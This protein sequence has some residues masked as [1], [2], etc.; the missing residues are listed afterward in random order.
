MAVEALCRIT[1][2]PLLCPKTLEKAL[3]SQLEMAYGNIWEALSPLRVPRS[4]C[5][6]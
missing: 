1:E 4:Q 5:I 6:E 2:S 3:R